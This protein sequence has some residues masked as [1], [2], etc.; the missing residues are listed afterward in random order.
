VHY[1]NRKHLS[2]NNCTIKVFFFFWFSAVVVYVYFDVCVVWCEVFCFAYFVKPNGSVRLV[3]FLLD[4]LVVIKR[5]CLL[6]ISQLNF[7][8]AIVG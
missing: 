3:K 8:S 7:N 2:T 4:V 6:G 5:F 1:G